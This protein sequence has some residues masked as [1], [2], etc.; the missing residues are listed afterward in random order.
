MLQI[1]ECQQQ[2]T[3]FRI[4]LSLYLMSLWFEI[5]KIIAREIM[6]IIP[7]RFQDLYRTRVHTN[8]KMIALFLYIINFSR[9]KTKD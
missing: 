4:I 5:K 2:P 1:T 3:D 6:D 9:T 7:E 8:I